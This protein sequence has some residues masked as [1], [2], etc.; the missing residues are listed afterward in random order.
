M[1][2]KKQPPGPRPKRAVRATSKRS[3]PDPSTSP[4]P[5]SSSLTA[6]KFQHNG[7]IKTTAESAP[8]GT[9][10]PIFSPP[11]ATETASSRPSI[12]GNA[13]TGSVSAVEETLQNSAMEPRNEIISAGNETLAQENGNPEVTP[14]IGTGMLGNAAIAGS[15]SANETGKPKKKKKK[16]VVKVVKKIV[17]KRVPKSMLKGLLARSNKELTTEEV[18]DDNGGKI[19]CGDGVSPTLQEVAMVKL[20]EGSSEDKRLEKQREIFNVEPTIPEQEVGKVDSSI[21][22]PVE[23]SDATVTLSVEEAENP[24][25]PVDASTE[26][27]MLKTTDEEGKEVSASEILVD[28][29]KNDGAVESDSAIA[30]PMEV[31]NVNAVGDRNSEF[32]VGFSTEV[33][34]LK[35]IDEESKEVSVGEIPVNG[36]KNDFVA[37]KSDSATAMPMEVV[38]LGVAGDRNSEFA[39]LRSGYG[40]VEKDVEKGNGRIVLSGELEALE[41]RRRRKTEI[42]IGGLNTV[43]KEEDV[44][45]VF[46]EVGNVV[47]VRLVI[48]S[49]TG[50]NKGFAF[51]RFASAA[52]AKKALDKYSNVEI[53]GKQCTTAPVE[54]NDT[55]FLGNIDKKW[56]NEDVIKL[57]QEIGIEKIDKVTVMIDPSNV[58]RNRGFAFLELET[59]KDAQI[60]LKKL[61]KKDLLKLQN[62]KVAWAEP[63]S[64]PDEEELLKVK[65]VYAEYLPSSWDEEKVGS[66]FTKFG[67]IENVVL[68]R[69]LHSSRRKDFAFIN[70]KNRE[71]ALACI[72]SFKNEML[73]VEGSQVNVKVSL[74]KPMPKGKPHK[75]VQKSTN[76][77][78]SKQKQ[79]NR[80]PEKPIEPKIKE[81]P[82]IQINNQRTD[83]TRSPGTADLEKLLAER[84]LW[85]QMQSRL[86]TG[87]AN[88]DYQ[89][90]SPGQKRTFSALGDNLNYSELRGY[91]RVRMENSFPAGRP[92]YDEVP[93]SFGVAPPSYYQQRGADYSIGHRYSD[94]A[95]TFQ[96]EDAPCRGNIGRDY[97]RY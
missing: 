57:L 33:E 28:G 4:N 12:I 91:P 15:E 53:C 60:A 78:I 61:Q 6:V 41:R 96:R 45:K 43:A 31:V 70:F 24:N 51:V 68:S 81:T 64:E 66:Y 84:A 16:V 94:Y 62:I 73:A 58:E 77:E 7:E 95:N 82:I 38:N 20:S 14:G 27:Q 76:K 11:I 5:S 35:T 1:A 59:Y 17:K 72:E 25:Q 9:A 86:G 34:K 63:L 10:L 37:E 90:S 55:L 75:K 23:I 97:Y 8:Q 32:S 22:V 30:K 44:R 79:V 92:S 85:K 93:P 49:K 46:E 56:K 40:E 65:S 18:L 67:E 39:G 2:P 83:D 54:G 50:K 29:E 69:N 36:E 80:R 52:D 71:A 42:F 13:E 74:A 87:M 48:N 47:E 3:V 21:S 89:Q 19:S 88:L 26:V